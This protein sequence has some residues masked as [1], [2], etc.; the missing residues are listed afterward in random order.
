MKTV[1]QAPVWQRQAPPWALVG[2]PQRPLPIDASLMRGA[3]S[4]RHGPNSQGLVQTIDAYR[5]SDTWYTF[6]TLAA[7]GRLALPW[8]A[9]QTMEYPDYELAARCPTLTLEPRAGAPQ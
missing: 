7:L 8:F 3:V 9:V 2:A 5:N 6:F 4:C 1:S